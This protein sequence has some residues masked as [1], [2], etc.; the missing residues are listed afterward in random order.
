M[1]ANWHGQAQV[2][3]VKRESAGSSARHWALRPDDKNPCCSRDEGLLLDRFEPGGE[4]D[5]LSLREE[6]VGGVRE[7]AGTLVRC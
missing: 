7:T 4:S 6:D 3:E 1:G 5:A 2:V